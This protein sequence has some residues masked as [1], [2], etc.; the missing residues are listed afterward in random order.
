MGPKY[1]LGK[2]TYIHVAPK[3][4]KYSSDDETGS[5]MSKFLIGLKYPPKTF[6]RNYNTVNNSDNKPKIKVRKQLDEDYK[7]RS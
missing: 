7:E 3:E 6:N 5:G 1:K 2:L 4:N